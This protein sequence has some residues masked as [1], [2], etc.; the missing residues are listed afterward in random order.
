MKQRVSS[1]RNHDHYEGLC[2]AAVSGQ[3][4]PDEQRE[5]K[6]HM[7]A[8]ADCRAF[9]G[10]VAE[11]VAQSIPE[12]A[13]RNTPESEKPAGMTSRFIARAHSEGLRL[14]R[15]KVASKK[16]KQHGFV[17]VA[18]AIAA[19]L[20]ILVL[21]RVFILDLIQTR[22]GVHTTAALTSDNQAEDS[23]APRRENAELKNK[24]AITQAEL[25]SLA[26]KVKSDQEELK[27]ADVWN[28]QLSS[29]IPVIEQANAGL[30]KDLTDKTAQLA[31]LKAEQDKL[32]SENES[33]R[34]A[35][36]VEEVELDGLRQRVAELTTALHESE[37][38]STAANQAK[39]IIF[40]R[41]LHIVDVDDTGPN[42]RRLRPFG[43][44]FYSEGKQLLF[45]AYDLSDTR[46]LNAKVNFY[47]WGSREGLNNP[48]RSLGIFHADDVK[49]GR[50]VL[51]FDDPNVLAQINCV[52][53]TAESDK[54]GVTQPTGR[55]ILFASLGGPNHP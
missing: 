40:A 42:G 11:I 34:V 29:R 19:L 53:V 15:S 9:V 35:S 1:L 27:L 2:A 43:R 46:K 14:K 5:L 36:E 28:S 21:M 50:W 25:D 31:Q 45:Y 39:D 7:S 48:V 52:F 44:I 38:L 32:V 17:I 10:D 4:Q 54:K 12:V 30:S 22:P 26:A 18:A 13:E 3:I 51:T 6:E 33:G 55:Q 24:L 37:Q 16:S 20:A 41:N 47:V 8:C 23:D 49:D